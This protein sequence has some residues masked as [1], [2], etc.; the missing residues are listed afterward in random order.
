MPIAF[1]ELEGSPKIRIIES[2]TVA[3]R[4]FR[5]AWDDW[6]DIARSLVGEYALVDCVFEFVPPLEFPDMP[7][8]VVSEIDVEPFDPGNPEG[9][10]VS[11]LTSGTNRYPDAGAK[12]TAQYRNLFDTDNT[13]RADLPGVPEG[14][15][16]TY[17]ADLSSETVATPGRTWQWDDG[18]GDPLPPDVRPK[19]IVPVGAFRLTWHRVMLPPWDAIRDLRGHVNATSFVGASAETVMFCGARI[20]R[21][22]QFLESGGY[23][24]VEYHFS[25][26]T[27]PLASGVGGW[28][29]VYK[30]DDGGWERVKDAAG[31]LP[32]PTGNLALLFQFGACP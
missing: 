21:E 24:S 31:D 1:E 3:T 25:E 8:L 6:V 16:L 15:Y 32:H 29:H 18:S 2:G 26:R 11:T 28:N 10:E 13:P 17:D 30:D 5:V 12:V 14:T 4:V 19:L 9:S 20:R 22:F 23:W 27:V 7:N